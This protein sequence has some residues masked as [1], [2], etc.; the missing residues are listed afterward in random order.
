M[1]IIIKVATIPKTPQFVYPSSPLDKTIVKRFAYIFTEDPIA[2]L[3]VSL[4]DGNDFHKW[5]L[6][7]ATGHV[8]FAGLNDETYTLEWM[9]GG[10]EDC[11][12]VQIDCTKLVWDLGTNYLPSKS[13]GGNLVQVWEQNSHAS[14]TLVLYGR[15]HVLFIHQ[16]S[17]TE[18]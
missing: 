10:Q 4:Y 7:N 13:G 1:I 12:Q 18:G 6:T 14:Q 3:N 15:Q 16:I 17:Q 5:Q 8:A 11:H 2:G 9:W